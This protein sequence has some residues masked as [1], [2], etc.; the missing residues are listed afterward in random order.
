MNTKGKVE[1][2][3]AK[4][5]IDIATHSVDK[6]NEMFTGKRDGGEDRKHGHE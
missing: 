5:S 3:I 4:T 1:C 2:R 6:A